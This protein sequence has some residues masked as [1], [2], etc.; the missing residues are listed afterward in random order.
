[1][2][3]DE[4]GSVEQIVKALVCC[5]CGAC[6]VICPRGAVR[7]AEGEHFNRAHVDAELCV[8]CGRCLGV[9]PAA[10][11]IAGEEGCAAR[12][13]EGFPEHLLLSAADDEVR[14]DGA[15]G[16]LITALLADLLDKGMIDG[17]VVVRQEEGRPLHCRPTLAQRA[18]DILAARGS[19][20]QPASACLGL[21]EVAER[22]GR[23]AFVGKGCEITALRKL[24][25]AE[26]LFEERIVL[27]VG[28]FCAATPARSSTRGFLDSVGVDLAGVSSIDYRGQ[29][30]PGMFSVM[31]GTRV[32]YGCAYRQAWDFLA[33]GPR[34]L[35]CLLCDDGMARA[36]DISAGDPWGLPGGSEA[37][38]GLSFALVRKEAAREALAQSLESGALRADTPPRE[39]VSGRLERQRSR[40]VR[41]SA[42][43]DT[44]L[45]LFRRKRVL[46]A[47]KGGLRCFRTIFRQRLRRDQY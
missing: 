6:A 23:Y 2:T 16:G 17:A 40:E 38:G 46:A 1:M 3:R 22:E 8:E 31:N 47:L 7:I 28:L 29:G 30:W 19:R 11:V 33:G 27:A 26:P 20:Y 13:T 4:S 32:I 14:R 34:S 36:S 12:H 42:A 44:Y 45:A 21:R 9:C 18:E 25:A 15:S 5:G 37:G 43:R 35:A 24:Q 39:W 10:G 41:A